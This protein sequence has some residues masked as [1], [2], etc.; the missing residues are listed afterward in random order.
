MIVPAYNSPAGRHKKPVGLREEQWNI[1][2]KSDSAFN[3]M[4]SFK[5]GSVAE[6]NRYSPGN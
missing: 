3:C 5:F 4:C 1:T 6:A 2:T